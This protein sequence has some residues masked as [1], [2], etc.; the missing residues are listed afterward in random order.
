MTKEKL[1][2]NLYIKMKELIKKYNPCHGQFVD[3]YFFCSRDKHKEKASGCCNG[4]KYMKNNCT[5]NNLACKMWICQEAFYSLTIINQKKWFKAVKAIY[6]TCLA[7]NIPLYWRA[8][9]KDHFTS[10]KDVFMI[11]DAPD[12]FIDNLTIKKKRKSRGAA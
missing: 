8:S 9:K 3:G 5:V 7:N 1:Y 2:S 11:N 4:C 12:W 6:D 10:E